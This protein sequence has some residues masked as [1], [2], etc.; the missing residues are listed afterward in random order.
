M[1]AENLSSQRPARILRIRPGVPSLRPRN[2]FA[3]DP[4]SRLSPTAAAERWLRSLEE[5]TSSVRYSRRFDGEA[6][7]SSS[8]A[9]ASSSTSGLRE[10]GATARRAVPDFWIGGYEDALTKAKGDVR[11]LLVILTCEEHD[12]DASFKA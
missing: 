11:V 7:S 5:S 4:S 2:P 12:D 10:R 8:S 3:R 1:G 6:G 9:V